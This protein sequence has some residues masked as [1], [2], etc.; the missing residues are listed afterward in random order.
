MALVHKS[1][2]R[3]QMAGPVNGGTG[4]TRGPTGEQ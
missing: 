2:A 3:G 4:S 1:G